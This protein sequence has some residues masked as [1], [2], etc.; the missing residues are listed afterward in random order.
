MA[1]REALERWE[2]KLSNC[3][4]TPQVIWPITKSLMNRDGPRA[5]TAIHGSSAFKFL[6]TDKS[7]AI[8]DCLEKMFTPHE[9]CEEHH[10]QW[11]ETSVQALLETDYNSLQGRV[12]PYDV[13]KLI[14][15]LDLKETSV[16]LMEF[17]TNAS[18]TLQGDHWYT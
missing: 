18:D 6:L 13:R 9:L 2:T 14:H 15:T 16:K 12:R 4:V 10:E 5:P 1:H 8:A 11:V 3:D 17:R 7:K